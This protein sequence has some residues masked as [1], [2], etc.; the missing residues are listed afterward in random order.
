MGDFSLIGRY[1]KPKIALAASLIL[2]TLVCGCINAPSNLTK[3]SDNPCGIKWKDN[4]NNED[5][6]NI[7]IGGSCVNCSNTT[8]WTKIA[9]TGPNATSYNWSGSCCN[10]GECSCVTVSAYNAN[11]ESP[12]SNIIMLAPVC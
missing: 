12:K 10:I 2:V 3:V 9:T 6:F 8:K 1:N 5:G 11:E 4:S 7:Y